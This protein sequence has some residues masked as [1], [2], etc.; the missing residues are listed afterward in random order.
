MKSMGVAAIAVVCLAAAGRLAAQEVQVIDAAAVPARDAFLGIETYRLWPQRAPRANGDGDDEAP[1]ITVFHPPPYADNGTAIVVTPGGGYINLAS[2]HEGR[3]IAD[4]FT[5]RGMTAFVLRYRVGPKARLPTPLLDGKRAVR[6]VRA[7]AARF[8]VAPDRIGMIGFSA[9][10]HLTATTAAEADVGAAEA[11]DPIERVG[12][13][14]N[15]V[16]LVYPW[17]NATVIGADGNS[18]Y[19]VFARTDCKPQDYI[20]YQPLKSVTKAFPPTFIFHTT[21]DSLVHPDGSIALY[22]ALYANAVPVEM[23]IFAKGQHGAGLGGVDP[24]LS[25]WPGLLQEWLRAQGL[26]SK[27]PVDA[28]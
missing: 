11:A 10:G 6:W 23:H 18:Q 28:R 14:L 5:S 15:F 2:I 19:C 25:L 4:W 3:Q 24:A 12:S 1:T 16:V 17:L 20:Q 27:K 7:N 22:Q 9:G 13:Q 26:M 21:E 8:H